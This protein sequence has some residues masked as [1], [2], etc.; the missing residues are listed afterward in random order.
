MCR[1][2]TRWIPW[3]RLDTCHYGAQKW[4]FLV[5]MRMWGVGVRIPS[6][7]LSRIMP[8][9]QKPSPLNPNM[10]TLALLVPFRLVSVQ[11][12]ETLSLKQLG[13]NTKLDE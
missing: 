2:Q 5:W 8:H 12:W 10:V 11:K 7:H 4:S 13:P 9:A 3:E 6:Q 1:N